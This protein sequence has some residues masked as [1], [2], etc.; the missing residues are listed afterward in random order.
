[1]APPVLGCTDPFASNYDPNATQDDGSCIAFVYGCTDPLAANY[2]AAPNVVEDGSCQYPGCMDSSQCNYDPNANVDDGS[3]QPFIVGCFDVT[4]MNYAGYTTPGPCDISDSTTCVYQGCMDT[5]ACNYN[6]AAT[7]D[8][9]GGVPP[10]GSFG[11]TSC[12][13]YCGDD[14][15]LN[16]SGVLDPNCTVACEYCNIIEPQDSD[17]I[18]LK[19]AFGPNDD[20]FPTNTN[21]SYN[22]STNTVQVN[23]HLQIPSAYDLSNVAETPWF[24]GGGSTMATIYEIWYVLE[25]LTTGATFQ[26]YSDVLTTTAAGQV[27]HMTVPMVAPNPGWSTMSANNKYSVTIGVACFDNNNNPVAVYSTLSYIIDTTVL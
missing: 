9:I 16:F 22:S 18:Y 1:M 7:F 19:T 17:G 26:Y 14:T 3:C 27:T 23:F 15:A 11:D 12:C 13:N 5:D 2:N 24:V 8:C 25:D 4:A 10:Q 6:P 21:Q 20:P